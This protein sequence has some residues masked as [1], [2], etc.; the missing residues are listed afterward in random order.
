MTSPV[1]VFISYSHKDEALLNVLRDHLSPLRRQGL[2]ADWHDRR[3]A[4][5]DRWDRE[6]NEQLER[7]QIVLLLLSASFIASD[8][9]DGIEVA[10]ALR[11]HTTGE[12]KVIPVVL[13]AV[14][15]EETKL[16]KLQALPTSGKPV[17]SWRDRDQ[18]FRDVARGVRTVLTR[19]DSA[20]A[21]SAPA[22]E[23]ETPQCG[24]FLN[25]TS[26]LRADPQAEFR[27]RTGVPLD[28]YDI[29]VVLDA[30][31]PEMLDAVSRVEYILDPAY[32]EPVQVRTAERDRQTKFLLKE[33]A[34]GEYLLR[35]RI[36]M[37][38]RGAPICLQRYITLWRSGPELT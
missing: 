10:A 22:I 1:Q 34:N 13:R 30:E 3:I 19:L 15:W 35:A 37:V 4:P 18:A 25:H 5:G 38:N 21:I 7:C 36:Y 32:P 9:I 6:I 31:E 33:L 26:F 20:P 11:R 8:Y 24:L 28:H 23:D 2:I 12:A 14:D 16:G 17:A 29:R 27:A